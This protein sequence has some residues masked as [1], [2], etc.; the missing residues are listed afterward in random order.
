MKKIILKLFFI[1]TFLAVFS[2]TDYSQW[3][4]YQLG[5]SHYPFD[6]F[7]INE[8]T[9]WA[10]GA[11]L[12]V[13]FTTNAG[14]NWVVI[15]D[16]GSSD[17]IECLHFANINT[18]WA[19]T[20]AGKVRKTTNGGLNWSESSVAVNKNIL[21]I[22]F[23]DENTGWLTGQDGLFRRTTNGGNSWISPVN[24]MSQTGNSV[25]FINSQ[26]GFVAGFYHTAVSTNGGDFWTLTYLGD[27]YAYSIKFLDQQTGW[28][29]GARV[30]NGNASGLY[31]L[32]T[33]NS[34]GNWNVICSD[35]A[36]Y[37]Y[38]T[39]TTD[40]FFITEQVGYLVGR[41][42]FAPPPSSWSGMMKKTTNGGISWFNFPG[43]YNQ[44]SVEA[45]T[46][47]N[48]QTGF[49]VG[50]HNGLGIIYKT[51]NANGIV[52]LNSEIP[53]QFSLYQNYP[54]PFNPQTKIKFQIPAGFATQTILTVYDIHGREVA[55]LINEQLKPGTYEVD[56]DSSSFPS[57]VYFYTITSG[58][59]KETRK[60]VLL[61]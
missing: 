31:V 41:Y 1:L 5:A 17:R 45:I 30:I 26:T 51:T 60:M 43:F 24:F 8:I 13:H 36:F 18:G 38:H 23:L 59:F 46:F 28:V 2:Q 54:N 55:V 27:V 49:A 15:S 50:N 44:Y 34:G 14:L 40:A 37:G 19:G 20:F 4:Q 33:I 25:H 29:I 61:K 32:K 3:S 35:S 48:N 58:S 39:V 10:A 21:D 57:G 16:P 9:G 56:W 47:V 42:G 6:V 12:I 7:F 22:Y 53:N 52:T 11:G